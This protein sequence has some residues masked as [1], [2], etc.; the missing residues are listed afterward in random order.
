MDIWTKAC[1]IQP[2]AFSYFYL[3]TALTAEFVQFVLG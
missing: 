1:S 2:E 3:L